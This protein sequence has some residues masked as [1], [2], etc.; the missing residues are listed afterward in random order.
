MKKY[1]RLQEKGKGSDIMD[2]ILCERHL[3][4]HKAH[5][6]ESVVMSCTDIVPSSYHACEDCF[7]ESMERNLKSLQGY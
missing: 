5:H 4:E 3:E 2:P 7:Q 6:G 1:F